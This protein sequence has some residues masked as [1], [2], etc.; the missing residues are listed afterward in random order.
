MSQPHIRKAPK[1]TKKVIGAKPAIL[2][3]YVYAQASKPT[4]RFPSPVRTSP[5]RTVQHVNPGELQAFSPSTGD[6]QMTLEQFMGKPAVASIIAGG[7]LRFHAVGDTGVGSPEQEAV[8]EAMAHDL[9]ADIKQGGPAFMLNLGDILYGP[10]KKAHY[11]DKFYRRYAD[12]H[13]LIFGIPGNHDGEVRSQADSPSLSAFLE[14]FCQPPGMQPPD[15]VEFGYLMPNQPGPYWSLECPFL[16][17]IGLYSN[18]AE[19]FGVLSGSGLGTFQM[20]W[21]QARLKDMA[22]AR[23]SGKRKAALVIAVHHPP[24]AAGLNETGFGHPSSL[25]ML[26]DIDRVCEAAGVMPDAVISGH[27]HTYQRYMRTYRKN[28]LE[29]TIPYF[30]AGTGGISIQPLPM[31]FGITR[32]D[33]QYEMGFKEYGYLTLTAQ[34]AKLSV[35]FTAVG[36]A[37]PGLRETIG[38]DLNTHKQV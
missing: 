10:D 2:D 38:I 8:A 13:R 11:A 23:K 21:L 3:K 30:V 1:A 32:G 7:Q 14:N 18:T 29:M 25:L 35:S 12:Y 17:L 33:V 16:D 9:A 26:E 28:G 27:A 20:D 15:G 5:F 22:A 6:A 19:N 36:G 37:N 31:P 4:P 34:A 24:Y